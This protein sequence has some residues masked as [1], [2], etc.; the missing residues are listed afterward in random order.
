MVT[1]MS[2]RFGTPHNET[3][4]M[5]SEAQGDVSDLLQVPVSLHQVLGELL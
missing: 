4:S 1:L 2:P 3:T 5:S